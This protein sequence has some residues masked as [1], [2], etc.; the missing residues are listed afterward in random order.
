MLYD[1]LQH[2]L[3]L[4]R[5][6]VVEE[7][8][9]SHLDEPVHDTRT[10]CKNRTISRYNTNMTVLFLL[11]KKILSQQRFKI[12]LLEPGCSRFVHYFSAAATLL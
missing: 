9:R 5:G 11:S 7:V 2:L 10:Q 1:V 3:A 12:P 6:Q 4:T 8:L